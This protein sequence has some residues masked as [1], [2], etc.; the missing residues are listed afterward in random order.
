MLRNIVH[1][2]GAISLYGIISIL[3]FVAVF[4]VSL[5]RVI[6]MNKSHANTMG[7]LPLEDETTNSQNKE[8]TSHE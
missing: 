5:I 3:L 4:G 2:M 8:N 6:F 7:S 1:E